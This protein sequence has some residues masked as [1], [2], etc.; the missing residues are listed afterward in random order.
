MINSLSSSQPCDGPHANDLLSLELDGNSRLLLDSCRVRAHSMGSQLSAARERLRSRLRPTMES[1][2]VPNICRIDEATKGE[3]SSSTPILAN[4]DQHRHRS[5]TVGSRMALLPT[6]SGA[7]SI[8][9]SSSHIGDESF[10]E[11]DDLMVIDYTKGNLV[12]ESEF[13]VTNTNSKEPI[14]T[15]SE[16]SASRDTLPSTCEESANPSA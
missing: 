15:L 3:K 8:D 4:A 13:N 5:A 2:L 12:M 16:Q 1:E 9:G 14:Y 6:S 11:D 7:P 10:D